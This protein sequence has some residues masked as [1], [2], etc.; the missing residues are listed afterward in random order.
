M[1]YLAGISI[2]FFLAL[3]LFSKKNKN[4][5]DKILACWLVVVGFHLFFFYAGITEQIFSQP[6]LLGIHLPVP[7]LHGPFLFLYARAQS[8]YLVKWN[9]KVSLHFLPALINYIYLIHFFLLPGETKIHV[10]KNQGDGYQVYMLINIAA[11]ILSGI[12]YIVL[13]TI[14]LNK[15]RK[16]I[17]NQFSS[18]EKINLAWLQYLLIGLSLIWLLVIFGND[19]LVF[20]ASVFFVLFIGYF[21]IKQVGIFTL[22]AA[23]LIEEEERSN[24]LPEKDSDPKELNEDSSDTLQDKPKEII[25]KKYQKSGLSESNAIELYQSLLKIMQVEK[26]YTDADLTLIELAKKLNTHPNYLSQVINQ[27]EKKNFYDFIN[28]ARVED[29]K[30]KM[31]DQANQKFT[32]VSLSFD[33]GFNSKSTFNK[34][35]KKVTGLSPTEYLEKITSENPT[36]SL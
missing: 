11:I 32:L 8:G 33:S 16:N 24:F 20:S 26:I 14:Q 10:Y 17:L 22:N 28:T 9:A 21:G 15:H 35:F 2:S 6:W 34:Y 30:E 3:I 12:I 7:L 1:F 18:T 31:K 13:T 5:A 25:R 27:F 29:M 23:P 19:T 4:L 36:S